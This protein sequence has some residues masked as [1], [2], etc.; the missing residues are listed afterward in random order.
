MCECP[1]VGERCH[2]EKQQAQFESGFELRGSQWEL[3]SH[4]VGSELP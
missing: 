3:T 4:K 2:G 1:T